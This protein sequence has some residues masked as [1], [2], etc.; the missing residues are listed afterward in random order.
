[1]KNNS[2]SLSQDQFPNWIPS[3]SPKLKPK[4][5]G[6]T[7]DGQPQGSLDAG[8]NQQEQKEI[9]REQVW[10]YKSGTGDNLVGIGE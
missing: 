9:Q 6:A 7:G 2:K 10:K 4:E 5:A 8:V 3:L 1:M